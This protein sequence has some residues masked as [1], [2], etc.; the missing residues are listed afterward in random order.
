MIMGNVLQAGLGQNPARQA[1]IFA[2]VP[3]ETTAFT[4]NKVCASGLKAVVLA[5]QSIM[6]GDSDISVAR[7][8]GK[9]ERSSLWYATCKV[10][11]SHGSVRGESGYTRPHGI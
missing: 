9:H 6:L 7:W 10:G 4:I 5:A 1:M 11:V 2:G 8:N 3:K